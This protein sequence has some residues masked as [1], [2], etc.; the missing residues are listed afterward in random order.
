MNEFGVVRSEEES[1][2]LARTA[3]R[4]RLRRMLLIGIPLVAILVA[5]W[6]YLTGGRYES[7]E[8]ASLQRGMVAVDS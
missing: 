5:A 7:T 6:I 8:N 4:A 3:S 2:D 1:E